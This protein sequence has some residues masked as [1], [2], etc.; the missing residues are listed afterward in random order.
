[1]ADPYKI[2]GVSRDATQ[3]AIREAYRALAKK[4]HPDLNPSDKDAEARFIEMAAAYGIIGD[5][6]KRAR[7]DKGEIDASGAPKQPQPEREFYRQRAE[8]GPGFKYEHSWDDA[9]PGV[10][11][12][13]FAEIFG[14]R[15]GARAERRGPDAGYTLSIEFLEAVNGARKRVTMPD[16]KSLE[17]S[18]PAGLKDGQILRLRGQGHPGMGG[19][20]P[21]DALV[22]VHVKP[23]PHFRREGNDIHSIL[24]VTPGEALGGAKL[25]VATVSGDV[26][27]TVPKGSNTGTILRLRD[28]GLPAAKGKGDHF[29]ELQVVLPKNADEELIRLVTEWEARHPSDP[30]TEK[31]AAS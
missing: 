26:Q 23:D 4:N 30:R 6:T 20:E 11:A 15:A 13:L 10:D 7:F 18:I 2:L 21:G 28:K 19:A 24:L 22:E 12:E 14:R 17:I 3:D 29:V 31:G 27:L 25:R 8:S 9:G 16:G 5:E 1:M